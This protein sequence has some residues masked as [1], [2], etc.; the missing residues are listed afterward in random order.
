MRTGSTTTRCSWHST[1][2]SAACRGA[3]GRRRWRDASPAR[4]PGRRLFDAIGA[5]LGHLPII[6]EDLGLITPEVDAL[7][8]SFDFPGMRV[9][10]FA[11]GGD[12]RNPYLPHN[13]QPDTV[14]YT[15]THDNDTT[16]G[17]WTQA[18]ERERAHL[19]AYLGGG[20][21]PDAQ[22]P[23]ALLRLACASVADT[24]IHPMQD[25]L[26]LPGSAR[27][28]L[29]GS[30]DGCWEWRFEWAQ[31]TPAFAYRLAH[32]CRLYGRLRVVTDPAA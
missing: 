25:V 22:V 26:S 12:S 8:T 15:G 32:M 23:W 30:G 13:F 4:W 27:M 17:W 21:L 18:G 16:L 29:P 10:Q 14:V 2:N 11:F 6:A 20:E 1:S 7:R 3:T 28:N 31:L 9:L 19:V 24:V 5:A